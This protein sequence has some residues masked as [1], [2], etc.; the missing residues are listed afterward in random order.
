MADGF[1]DNVRDR[2]VL[3]NLL[4][5]KVCGTRHATSPEDVLRHPAAE[6]LTLEYSDGTINYNDHTGGLG[7]G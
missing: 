7:G 1:L 4:V 3:S 6:A 2:T 5:A